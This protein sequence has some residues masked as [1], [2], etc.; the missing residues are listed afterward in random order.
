MRAPKKPKT[1]PIIYMVKGTFISIMHVAIVTRMT[2][3]EIKAEETPMG[4]P[5]IKQE[6]VKTE[7]I[8][9]TKLAKK[10]LMKRLISKEPSF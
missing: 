2:C 5:V 4:A 7:P 10:P 1:N 9:F 8:K 6:S 3:V